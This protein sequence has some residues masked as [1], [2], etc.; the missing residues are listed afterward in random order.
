MRAVTYQRKKCIRPLTF[1]NYFGQLS[2]SL[3]YLCCRESLQDMAWCCSTYVPVGLSSPRVWN[4]ARTILIGREMWAV[5]PT[6]S[7][8]DFRSA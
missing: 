8:R 4:Q 1:E 2:C 6:M 5:S 3:N 7:L